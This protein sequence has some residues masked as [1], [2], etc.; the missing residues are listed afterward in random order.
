MNT[1]GKLAIEPLTTKDVLE[2]DLAHF[3]T[4]WSAEQWHDLNPDQT[5]LFTFRTQ[6][7][8]IGYS[9]FGLSPGDDVAHL[10]KILIDPS[11]QHQGNAVLFWSQIVL[12]LKL[13]KLSRVYLEVE[14]S[15]RRAIHF[16]EKAGLRLIRLNKRYYSN[17][18]DALMMELLL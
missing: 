6:K 13:K 4:P 10:F 12:D 8:L 1:T 15:N 2:L 11:F 18:E 3:P 17:G 9:L 7:A 14:A 16:Y 5:I